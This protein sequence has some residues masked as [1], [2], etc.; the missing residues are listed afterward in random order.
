MEFAVATIL[1]I[2]ALGVAGALV[3]IAAMRLMPDTLIGLSLAAVLSVILLTV[4][5]AIL[6]AF[7]YGGSGV[8][9]ANRLGG[10]FSV[11]LHFVGLGLRA[12][13]VWA[14]VLLLTLIALGQGI[15]RRRGER[16][17]ARDGD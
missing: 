14:P 4:G 8:A 10:A 6:F 2:V 16:L 17:A 3:P 1:P 15:E 11:P 12:A 13:L 5:G 7:I 9:V